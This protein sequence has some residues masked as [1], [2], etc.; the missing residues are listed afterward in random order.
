[1]KIPIYQVD[2]FT[3]E[4]FSGNP[5]AV[6]LL[7][8]WI[9]DNRLQSIAAE[10]NLSETAFLVKNDAGFDLRWFTPATEVALC[11]HAT[12]ASAFVLFTCLNYPKEIIRFQTRM[13]G[14][15]TVLKRED[16]LEMDFPSRPVYARTPPDG[17][18]EGLGILP[19]EV[20]DSEED[21]LVV[22]DSEKTVREVRPDFAALERVVCRCVIIT[23][24]GDRS[25]FVS[26]CFAPRVGIP[27]DP[28]TGSAHCVLI[29]YWAGVF[30]KN[31]LHAFQVSKRG[32]ELFC[33]LAGDRVKISGKA[34][35]YMEGAI[36]I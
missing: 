16:L 22:L 31:D 15:L 11:G 20:F 35:L 36:T 24:R 6:C 29:P 3:S 26:R 33:K 18:K 2:A 13:S 8:A 4:I 28:V 25:D 5:A 10:N 17:L 21:L 12:L 32:G 30:G 34:V 9:D 19:E 23:A 14:E 7:D 1:M 27:E